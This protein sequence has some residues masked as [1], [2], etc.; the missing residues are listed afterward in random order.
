MSLA[1]KTF[2]KIFNIEKAGTPNAKKV[3]AAEVL[4]TLSSLK[5]PYPNND[6]TISSD[7]STKAVAAG[8]DQN[9]HN[10]KALFCKFVA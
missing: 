9:K 5:E 7:A 6:V 4:F 1:K 2:E 3:S 10:S 8:I